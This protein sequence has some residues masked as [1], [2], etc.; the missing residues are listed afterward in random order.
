M[1]E[2]E[3]QEVEIALGCVH[4][5]IYTAQKTACGQQ[6]AMDGVTMVGASLAIGDVNCLNCSKA[7]THLYRTG[8]IC[9]HHGLA[10]LKT[11]CPRCTKLGVR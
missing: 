9:T 1:T 2:K 6:I 4:W 3:A 7:Y 10:K 11:Q 8:H 5:V